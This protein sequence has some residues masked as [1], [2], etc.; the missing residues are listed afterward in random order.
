MS[1]NIER[2]SP[3][4]D[5]PDFAPLDSA[6]ACSAAMNSLRNSTSTAPLNA[7]KDLRLSSS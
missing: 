5:E 4:P 6:D 3:A 7:P 1:M 2:F